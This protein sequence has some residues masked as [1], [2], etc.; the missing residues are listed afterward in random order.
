MFKDWMTTGKAIPP[1]LREAVYST[2]IRF[3]GHD[4]WEFCWN[5]Y[6]SSRFPSEQRLM[7]KALSSTRSLWLLNRY[8][9]YS[10]DKD[11]IRTQDTAQVI[12]DVARNP[13]VR[14]LSWRFVRDNWATIFARFGQG[15]FSIDAIISQTTW[16][17]SRPFDYEEV[18]TFFRSVSV[19]SGSQAVRQSLERIRANIHW[20][21][22]VE[23]QVV[24]WLQKVPFHD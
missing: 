9:N 1:N 21:T 10:L 4:E 12:S 11:K 19:G 20:K 17:F 3:G 5:R 18:D 7:L 2:G 22:H 16:G 23:D 13:S 6:K 24:D 15:S 14:L 8:L